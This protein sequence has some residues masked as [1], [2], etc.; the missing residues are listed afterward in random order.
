MRCF[1]DVEIC[2]V[3]YVLNNMFIGSSEAPNTSTPP[4]GDDNSFEE[5][6]QSSGAGDP[7]ASTKRRRSS[8]PVF[9]RELGT[10]E[11][12]INV[13]VVTSLFEPTVSREYVWTFLFQFAYAENTSQVKK[14][15]ISIPLETTP[16]VKGDRSY[17]V[18]DVT[19]EPKAFTPSF[20]VG[21]KSFNS[22][23]L[24]N[25]FVKFKVYHDRFRQFFNRVEAF[26][27]HGQPLHVARP[28]DSVIKSFTYEEW[29]AL[30]PV[31][32]QE[33]LR[34]KNVIVTGWPLKEK[35]SFDE[36]GLRKVAGTQSRQ[37]SINGNIYIINSR[38]D[39]SLNVLYTYFVD[40]SIKPLG[41]GCIP[42]VVSGRV[43]DMWNNR[44]PSGKILNALD[45]PLYDGNTEPTEYAS[46]LHA[47]D[48]TRGHHH[49]DQAS[50]YPTEH[51]RWALLGHEH[52]ITFLHIDCEGLSTDL[53]VADGGKVWGFLRER[54]GN[55]L[56]SINF[57]LKDTFR[58]DEVLDS[59]DYD[60]EAVALRP[61]DRL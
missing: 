14:E 41:N 6:T 46:D 21:C 13:D 16:L 37:I 15:E 18:L 57:F 47:W 42:T 35:I 53:L 3:M 54:L 38:R 40:Y 56:S 8:S 36:E 59:S 17:T 51:M 19:G 34:K 39:R 43:R 20:H 1:L 12:P 22:F 58:L 2:R 31:K 23:L 11:T 26:Y 4:T 61:R 7:N 10:K 49:V 60:F 52:A 55:P 50:S 9:P 33:E 5:V 48:V 45:L 32:M 30:T 28:G 44:H 24:L 25:F 27:D 29:K